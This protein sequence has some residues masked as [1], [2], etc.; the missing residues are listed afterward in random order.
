MLAKDLVGLV[1][2]A[3][4]QRYLPRV[5]ALGVQVICLAREQRLQIVDT[6]L[7]FRECLFRLGLPALQF[8]Q[9]TFQPRPLLSEGTRQFGLDLGFAIGIPLFQLSQSYLKDRLCRRYQR[10]LGLSYRCSRS[11]I[12]SATIATIRPTASALA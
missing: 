4:G 6:P 3:R 9:L 11:V 2:I 10:A 1:Q 8:C 5:A 12:S 7:R